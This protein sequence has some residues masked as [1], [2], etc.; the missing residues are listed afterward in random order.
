MLLISLML[1]DYTFNTG[2]HDKS[3]VADERSE[4][5]DFMLRFVRAAHETRLR[6]SA[7]CVQTLANEDESDG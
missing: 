2:A 3:C 6:R 1:V 5:K 4:S 7:C